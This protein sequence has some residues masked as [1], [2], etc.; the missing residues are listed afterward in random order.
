MKVRA[1]KRMFV[2]GRIYEVGSV[3]DYSGKEPTENMEVVDTPPPAP[4]AK[5]KAN[6]AKKPTD[7]AVSAPEAMEVRGQPRPTLSDN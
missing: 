6:R 4:K 5:K 7:G 3:F 1:K 2:D